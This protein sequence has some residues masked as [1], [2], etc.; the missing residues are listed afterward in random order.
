MRKAQLLVVCLGITLPYTARSLA[1]LHMGSDWLMQFTRYDPTIYLWT[2]IP[3]VI[4]W[5][6]VFL[7]VSVYRHLEAAW[8]P[9]FFGFTFSAIA[10]AS[11][12]LTSSPFAP[13]ALITIP[14]FSLPLILIGF[15]IG[16]KY[17]KKL[18]HTLEESQMA[19]RT[20]RN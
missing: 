6:S 2:N 4:C 11:L 20:R 17:N 5:G 16:V 8:F 3:N 7:A 1:A 15:F 18:N 12:D 13:V 9:I 10:Y 14:F 19:F